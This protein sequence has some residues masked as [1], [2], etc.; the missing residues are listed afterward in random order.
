MKR[1][2]AFLLSIVMLVSACPLTAFAAGSEPNV[3]LDVS[4]TEV[5]VGDVFTVYLGIK[6]MNASSVAF[7][8]DFDN[9]LLEVKSVTAVRNIKLEYSA[10][11]PDAEEYYEDTLKALTVSNKDEANASGRVG[12]AFVNTE[13]VKYLENE[14]VM[15]V[16][17]VAKATGTVVFA[18]NEDSAGPDGYKG[19][20]NHAKT[21]T[22]SEKAAPKYNITW[23]PANGDEPYTVVVEEG[24]VPSYSG[25][26]PYK[27]PDAKFQYQFKGAEG[28]E[29]GW[30][31][32][33]YPADKDQVYTAQYT[34]GPKNNYTITWV[35]GNDS[36][37][38]EDYEYGAEPVLPEELKL[39]TGCVK[40][41]WSPERAEVTED[42][43]Y[44]AVIADAHTFVQTKVEWSAD[45]TTCT[46]YAECKNCDATAKEETDVLSENVGGDCLTEGTI[47]YTAEFESS[48]AETATKTESDGFGT[49]KYKEVAAQPEVHTPTELKGA[50]AAHYQCS[51]CEKLF[52]SMIK[53]SETDIGSLTGTTPTHKATIFEL[54]DSETHNQFCE[55]G[56]DMGFTAH[57]YGENHQCVCG[58]AE[59]FTLY[60]EGWYQANS[61]TITYGQ[62]ESEVRR[63]VSDMLGAHE[64]K[65]LQFY[66]DAEHTQAYTGNTM[67]G[68][69][70]YA[71]VTLVCTYASKTHVTGEAATCTAPGWNDYYL[72]ECGNIYADEAGSQRIDE[73][74]A[75]KEGAGAIAQL[76]HVDKTGDEN[77]LCDYGCGTTASECTYADATCTA[78]ATCTECGATSG[79]PLGHTW[80]HKT[81]T[82][83][84]SCKCGEVFK[85]QN[86]FAEH[87]FKNKGNSS[88]GMQV[89]T[90]IKQTDECKNC[91]EVIDSVDKKDDGD[92]LCDNCD[93]YE[94]TKC[95]EVTYTSNNPNQH[96][97]HY[98]CG[99]E[100][101]HNH[102][103]QEAHTFDNTTHK[104]VCG[105]VEHF[106]I[107]LMVDGEQY[108][109]VRLFAYGEKVELNVT[110]VK[111]PVGCTT[112]TFAGW[113]DVPATMPAKNL[114]LTAKFTEGTE[115]TSDAVKYMN[116]TETTHD[117]HYACCD[118][119]KT[120]SE[121][122]KYVNGHCACDKV[123]TFTITWMV[124]GKVHATTTEKYGDVLT[125][126]AAPEAP[127]GKYFY[128]WEGFVENSSTAWGD[129]NFNAVFKDKEYMVT[130]RMD[131]FEP[132][133][134]GPFKHGQVIT[135]TDLI[136]ELPD[137]QTLMMN[138]EAFEPFA[139]TEDINAEFSIVSNHVWKHEG[140]TDVCQY[141]EAWIPG[142]DAEGD[143]DHLCDNCKTAVMTECY[144][145]TATCETKAVCTECGQPYGDE[146]GHD[147]IV[148]YE[149]KGETHTIHHICNNDE[150][151]NYDEAN[152]AHNF[153]NEEHRCIC[154]KLETFT[155]TWILNG[156][157]V[158][159]EEVGYREHI[160]DRPAIE[161][162][163]KY[164]DI[165]WEDYIPEVIGDITINGCWSIKVVVKDF[166]GNAMRFKTDDF[167]WE[168]AKVVNAGT[169]VLLDYDGIDEL[170]G[171]D[172]YLV[173]EANADEKYPVSKDKPV[174]VTVNEN[175][176]FQLTA[177]PKEY[178]VTWKAYGNVIKTETLKYGTAITAPEAP[179][180]KPGEKF[181]G[182]SDFTAGETTVTGP[183]TFEAVFAKIEYS[184][185]IAGEGYTYS[186]THYYGDQITVE[187]ILINKLPACQTLMMNGEPF[188]T[189]TVTDNI[190]AELSIAYNHA[191]E[192]HTTSYQYTCKCGE[193]FNNE[194]DRL[195][196][197]ADN[198]QDDSH[199]PAGAVTKHSD[200]CKHCNTTVVSAD[201]ENDGNHRCDNCGKVEITQCDKVTYTN[202]GADHTVHY[203]CANESAHNYDA[204]NQAHAYDKDSHK[205]ACGNVE[206]FTITLNV[207]GAQFGE[208]LTVAFGAEVKLPEAKKAADG[209]TVFNFAGWEG[210]PETMPAENLTLNAKFTEEIKHTSQ[211]LKYENITDETHDVHHDCCGALIEEKVAHAY[212]NGYCDCGKVQTFTV[213]LYV[214]KPSDASLSN[215]VATYGQ[216]FR[217]VLTQGVG[218]GIRVVTVMNANGKEIPYTF[219]RETKEL[220]VAAEHVTSD[221]KITA[222]CTVLYTLDAN[223]G[224]KVGDVSVTREFIY[225]NT[226]GVDSF[227]SMFQREGYHYDGYVDSN[228]KEYLPGKRY[229][230]TD[231][232]TLYVNWVPNEYELS[233]NFTN[234]KNG[235]R[236]PSLIEM[237]VTVPYGAKLADYIPE[238]NEDGIPIYMPGDKVTVEGERYNGT[239]TVLEWM[240]E[241][242]G[243][244]IDLA[245]ATM[246]VG[247]AKINQYEYFTGWYV[248]YYDF[249]IDDWM[250][251][252]LGVKYLVDNAE[253]KGWQQIDGSWYYF[254]Y[255]EEQNKYFRAEGMSRA[256]YP[257]VSING[258]WYEPDEE[259]LDYY[260]GGFIDAEEGWFLFGEDGKFQF[261]TTGI[262]TYNGATRYMDKGF[263]TWHY[264]LVKDGNDYY[265][266]LGDEAEGG[267]ILATGDVILLNNRDNVKFTELG[268]LRP[269]LSRIYTF[270]TDGKLC[271]YNGIT[272]M[273]DGSKRFYQNYRLMT[274]NGLTK[275]GE[276][277][278]YVNRNGVLVVDKQYWVPANNMGVEEGV[279]YFD[280]NGYLQIPDVTEKNGAYEENGAWYY[281]VDGVLAREAGLIT[282]EDMTWYA[283][284]GTVTTNSGTIYVRSNGA[285]AVGNYWVTNI[286]EYEGNDVKSGDLLR[287]NELGLRIGVK[288]GIYEEGGTLYYYKSGIRGYN[289]G[290]IELDGK[291]Y[292]VRSN[293]EVVHGKSYWITNVGDTGVI[294]QSYTF[295]ADGSFQPKFKQDALN[296]IHDGYYYVDNRIAYN[297]GVVYLKEEGCYIY[298]RS[299]GQVATGIYWA[300][301]T[302]GLLVSKSYDWG[303]DGKLYL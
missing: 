190:R 81:T 18:M 289:A 286:E 223:G 115:H 6:E 298:V 90:V 127:E 204:K 135:V 70:L 155:V 120:K 191:W 267:N 209:C 65:T 107:T 256:A 19:A 258:T 265:Y 261:K 173:N 66:K 67:P 279:Y 30:L 301:N 111:N 240:P 116:I 59:S 140:E 3:T 64:L 157:I 300:T 10:Y 22:I 272:D 146:L 99:N 181:T 280:Q 39:P 42:T 96:S 177:V 257:T 233:I 77:H 104:C 236:D 15:S 20:W 142:K 187:K 183:M 288:N 243:T 94:L 85:D 126:P 178:T 17:F 118:A 92:H 162:P 102:N 7:Y 189:I 33:P 36:Y 137:C 150:S 98:T 139:I 161:K 41:T 229:T 222:Q 207:D 263:L 93:Q 174:T 212:E 184:V 143:K 273:A 255:N 145:G 8:F 86:L 73:L 109:N 250:E 285:L 44:T 61:L 168:P 182:W 34:P 156:D 144:G 50:V 57:V 297:A 141:C 51:V 291:Y 43:T 47:T 138:G 14:N 134:R 163:E 169:Q 283:A 215:T 192:H 260:E 287:F 200:T 296:G 165:V 231:D 25:K 208:K 114:T 48:W 24:T 122:H 282:V 152:V 194:W 80:E 56:L 153:E 40:V 179:T 54:L 225:G 203:T 244:E 2:I 53:D 294:A 202:N 27:A 266:F 185:I 281:Y 278:I 274:G 175:T 275:V 72:C 154:G 131:G 159:T 193:G 28:A 238:S 171:H 148:N 241:G 277:F 216:E 270:G 186:A 205:C 160:I 180:A 210:A 101:A 12:V 16:K 254:A 29:G 164:F 26:E 129:E 75:W 83:T 4:A 49:H 58:K 52:T 276:N 290:V 149:N 218:S 110:P 172:L 237:I 21:V 293:A 106:T 84:V 234:F 108:G 253:L 170:E 121:A 60:I 112:Y 196:H 68:Q 199:G 88:H 128:G 69:D 239:Y 97:V 124:N 87:L 5:N 74:E 201:A 211:E 46:A 23:D 105:Y 248:E 100:T 232:T 295:A 132:Q 89:G 299:N 125:A 176:V 247:G 147:W 219:D 76:P 246:P 71:V 130:V 269:V 303:T 264:G 62:P 251:E 78:P 35:V 123:Q 198:T 32:A 188:K 228:G 214:P 235:D 217:T 79:E 249:V 245:T 38:R 262:D 11:D 195:D 37:S 259:A 133:E 230:L 268:N 9:T 103:E 119:L 117:V 206:T 166:D 136:W 284:D 91:H 242:S 63:A 158:K 224:E 220:V 151:H 271:K 82:Y 292:Y 197:W 167:E 221:I 113:G 31:P 13:D 226:F 252:P 302:N 213:K 1:I 95:N 45:N 227:M 55:C